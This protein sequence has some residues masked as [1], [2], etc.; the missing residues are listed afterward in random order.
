MAR[1]SDIYIAWGP[2]VEEE[3]VDPPKCYLQVG[4]TRTKLF[5]STLL[6]YHAYHMCI[7]YIL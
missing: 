2:K 7:L 4:S 3:A 5:H 1:L 6:K